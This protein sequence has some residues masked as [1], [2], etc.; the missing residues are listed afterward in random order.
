M[1][2]KKKMQKMLL[3]ANSQCKERFIK[4]GRQGGQGIGFLNCPH[5]RPVKF[6]ITGFVFKLNINNAPICAHSDFNHCHEFVLLIVE[7]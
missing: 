7:R 4:A 2:I 3:K 1:E 6:S 5:D